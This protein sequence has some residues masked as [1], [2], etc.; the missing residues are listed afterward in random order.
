MVVLVDV[1]T[2]E[3]ATYSREELDAARTRLA[4]YDLIGAVEVRPLL[5]ALG[6][7][8]SGRRLA[9]LGPPQKTVKLN[10]YGRT[11][12]DAWTFDLEWNGDA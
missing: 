9:E 11:L 6:F 12:K 3:L 8:P 4:E 5:K 10:R 7:D 2:R 1:A